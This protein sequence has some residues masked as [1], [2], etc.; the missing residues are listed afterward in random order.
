MSWIYTDNYGQNVF[1]S[2]KNTGFDLDCN[3]MDNNNQIYLYITTNIILHYIYHNI[4]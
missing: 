2:H 1:K 3:P 4:L